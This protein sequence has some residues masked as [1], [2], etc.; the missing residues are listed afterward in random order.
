M[1]MAR[2]LEKCTTRITAGC[3]LTHPATLFLHHFMLTL[4]IRTEIGI[5]LL[6]KARIQSFPDWYVFLGKPTVV[7]HKLLEKEGR[8]AEKH[9]C[10]Y[11]QIGNAVPPL[12]APVIAETI[13][14][15]AVGRARAVLL[16]AR[17]RC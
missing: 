14:S 12:M 16:S 11:S 2:Y 8:T 15:P 6:A 3:F 7:S 10:Q 5:L 13:L 1:E 17:R 9:L 4:F